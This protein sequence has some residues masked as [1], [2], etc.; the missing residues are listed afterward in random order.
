MSNV[1]DIRM[2]LMKVA[3]NMP[4]DTKDGSIPLQS[5]IDRGIVQVQPDMKP[6]LNDC[7]QAAKAANA[8]ALSLP[9]AVQIT[10]DFAGPGTGGGIFRFRRVRW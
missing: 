3:V 9:T 4:I 7:D 1:D 6:V 5:L 2:S 8:E 10:F